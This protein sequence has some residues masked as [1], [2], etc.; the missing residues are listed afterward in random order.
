MDKVRFGIIGFGGMGAAH[1]DYL[2]KSEV[3]NAELVAACD[4]DP[5]R[6]KVAKEKFGEKFQVFD[7]ADAFFAAKAVDA[8]LIATPHYFH[9]PLAIKAFQNGLH[10]LTEKPAG[11]YTKQVREMNEAAAKSG[12]V[13]G[14]MFQMR[15]TPAYQK[16]RDLVGSGELGE[17][18]RSVFFCT[19]WFRSQCYYDSGT[20]RATWGGEGGGVLINQCPHSLDI[21]QWTSGL[22]K[23][24]RAFCGFGKH[25]NIEVEDDV[26]AYVE[27]ANGATGLFVTTT[28]E[29]PGTYRFE[30][31]GDRGKLTFDNSNILKFCRTRVSVA[32]Y[33]RESTQAFATPECWTCEVPPGGSG[34][35]H[36][37]VTR[38]FV[39]AILK[40]GKPI[41]PGEE[42]IR[43][44]EISNAMLLSAWTD[45]WVELPIN[46]DLFL[47]KLQ[48][49][50]K[51]SKF[52]KTASGQTMDF[53]TSFRPT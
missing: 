45:S 20:W 8:V 14:I 28:G 27:Y 29:A 11:V 21:W 17:L 49:R 2:G 44:L 46:E 42:G 52:K 3:P 43:S 30:L 40:G 24:V 1:G 38:G 10:V 22:P 35:N 18:R 12:K 26:T 13:F 33:T 7:N 16:I 36:V 48:E 4:V 32:Q 5:A 23:R 15:T 41:I 53:S 47:A 9:P 19:D 25:H 39:N 34:G 31:S 51:S 50:I 6:L 37:T